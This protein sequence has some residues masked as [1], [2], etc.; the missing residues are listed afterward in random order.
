MQLIEKIGSSGRTRTY[1]P[2]VNT[3][4]ERLAAW[5]GMSWT[6]DS[7]AVIVMKVFGESGKETGRELWLVP[8]N[9][10]AARKLDI[11]VSDWGAGSGNIRLHP[12]G[13]QI[14]FFAGKQSEEIWALENF[15]PARN[16]GE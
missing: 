4:P 2:P 5:G 8:I 10:A 7:Q 16:A 13:R 3:R 9:G 6:P 14:A 15:L 12:N 11:D 1:N